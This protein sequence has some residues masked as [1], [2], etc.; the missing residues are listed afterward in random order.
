ME[1]RAEQEALTSGLLGR[2]HEN[3]SGG[4]GGKAIGYLIENADS[5]HG[6]LMVNSTPIVIALSLVS[7]P[8]IFGI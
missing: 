4:G 7:S 3:M 8:I 2:P 1:P 5:Q 6:T